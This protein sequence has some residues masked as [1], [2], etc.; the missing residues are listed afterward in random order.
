MTCKTCNDS[1]RV[2][3]ICY[4]PMT[5]NQALEESITPVPFSFALEQVEIG[6]PDC[7]VIP[8]EPAPRREGLM[9]ELKTKRS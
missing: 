4:R 9:P 2:Y 7:T 6:C 5:V 3:T 8:L 1:R